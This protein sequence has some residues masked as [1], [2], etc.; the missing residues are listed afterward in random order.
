MADVALGVCWDATGEAAA[1]GEF[2]ALCQT[3][4][5]VLT[6][7]GLEAWLTGWLF[8]ARVSTTC[9]AWAS[10]CPATA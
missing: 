8:V 3:D 9:A 1:V 5:V 2:E 10:T 4:C 6:W 7:V